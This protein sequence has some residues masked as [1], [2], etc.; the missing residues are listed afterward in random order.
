MPGYS[1]LH[2]HCLHAVY[3]DSIPGEHNLAVGIAVAAAAIVQMVSAQVKVMSY[4]IAR[5][6]KD[7]ASLHHQKN[8][9]WP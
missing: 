1:R 8:A 6:R 7:F 4:L 3:S 2:F 5:L 9:Y